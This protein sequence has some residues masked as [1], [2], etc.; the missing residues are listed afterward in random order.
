[1]PRYN[2][3][4]TKVVHDVLTTD[5]EVIAADEAEAVAKAMDEQVGADWHYQ[6]SDG[7]EDPEVM[8]VTKV[9]G[10]YLIRLTTDGVE[11]WAD[12]GDGWLTEP[13]GATIFPD[14]KQLPSE[15]L[16][17]WYRHEVTAFKAVP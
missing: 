11:Y 14:D 16:P 1:M 6:F 13:E 5:I 15:I 9:E 2:I 3:R 10:F 7:A 4:L 8:E 12:N 17:K